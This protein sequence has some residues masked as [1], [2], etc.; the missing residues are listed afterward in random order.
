MQAI[1]PP[2]PPR[3]PTPLTEGATPD[4]AGS[5]TVERSGPAFERLVAIM[6]RLRAPG[7]CPW[8]AEQTH[9]SLAVHLL[10]E[11]NETLDAIDSANM[12]D[13]EEELGDLLLQV[14]FHAEIAAETG[15]FEIGDVIDGLVKKLVDRHPHV[16]GE[17]KVRG[18]ADVVANW[19]TLKRQQKGRTK[20]DEGLPKG[21]PALIYAHKVL[22]RVSGVGYDFDASPERLA[23]LSEALGGEVT[24]DTVAGLLLEVVALAGTAGIDPEGALRRRS[25][26]LMQVAQKDS[27]A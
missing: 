19:E 25:S 15:Q 1:R 5:P 26:A 24:E 18:S 21:L 4:L 9:Q 2:Q 13:L 6:A 16:F 22:R 3:I 11:A 23:K 17:I 27:E 20:L 10:E 12:H 8:D 7:G 14:V